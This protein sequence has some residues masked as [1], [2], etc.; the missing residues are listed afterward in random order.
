[1]GWQQKGWKNEVGAGAGAGGGGGA[2]GGAEGKGNVALSE[3]SMGWRCGDVRDVR[4]VR[5]SLGVG[6]LC[7]P[8]CG[9]GVFLW[10]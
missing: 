3:G 9:V 5:G 8:L 6:R 1:M 2:G 10:R 7:V 4:G